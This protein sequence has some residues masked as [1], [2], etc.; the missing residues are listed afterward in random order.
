MS[1][2]KV[3]LSLSDKVTILD[4]LKNGE[5][6][7]KILIEKKIVLRTLQRIIKDET[8]IRQD[9]ASMSPSRKRKRTDRY[10]DIDAAMEKWFAS[11]RA[12]K[13]NVIGT[14]ILKRARSF[15]KELGIQ[16]YTPSFGW[17]GRWKKRLGICYKKAHGEK[18]SANTEA[19]E[20]WIRNRMPEILLEYEEENIFNADETGLFYRATPDG[21]L[22]FKNE[23][24]TG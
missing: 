24:L 21:T 17:L 23:S 15:A 5:K 18:G 13:K 7:D 8:Q 6:K 1:S 3:T 22:C 20:Q 16:P 4:R 2:K 12:Q 10:Q 11:M 14:E 19:A 9:A